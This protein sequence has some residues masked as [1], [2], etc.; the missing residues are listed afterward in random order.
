MNINNIL[1]NIKHVQ[2]RKNIISLLNTKNIIKY[3]TLADFI[4]DDNPHKPTEDELDK[5]WLDYEQLY[6]HTN[7]WVDSFWIKYEWL[8]NEDGSPLSLEQ[9]NIIKA[10]LKENSSHV[11]DNDFRLADNNTKPVLGDGKIENPGLWKLMHMFFRRLY[12]LMDRLKGIGTGPCPSIEEQLGII[13]INTSDIPLEIESIN[14]ILNTTKKSLKIKEDSLL[15]KILSEIT[16]TII[17]KNIPN[18]TRPFGY[19]DTNKHYHIELVNKNDETND[20]LKNQSYNYL[21]ANHKN[22]NLNNMNNWLRFGKND[23][24]FIFNIGNV[25]HSSSKYPKVL[26]ISIVYNK[27][28]IDNSLYQ[29]LKNI[30]V[31]ILNK[32]K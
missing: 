13:K 1:D 8:I 27:D 30:V 2:H 32:Y 9:K 18:V 21:I 16:D 23:A 7:H 25:K 11:Q 17:S 10:Y 20:N 24:S 19:T 28:G 31:D 6:L 14:N 5:L 15:S 22:I 3:N 26:H 4:L 29:Q 12:C